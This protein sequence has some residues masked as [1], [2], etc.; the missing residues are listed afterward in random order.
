MII[1]SIM[2]KVINAVKRLESWAEEEQK[3]ETVNA[4]MPKEKPPETQVQS[5]WDYLQI[6]ENT[7][8][9]HL[10]TTVGFEEWVEM[11]E[12]KRRIKELFGME[13]KNERSL[14]PYIKTLADCNLFEFSDIGGK[15]KWRKKALLL[16]FRQ[17][18]AQ[19]AK[20]ETEAEKSA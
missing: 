9:A 1:K 15:R 10:S 7:Q 17:A 20:Q 3:P 5:I 14:Y 2:R 12:I 8:A 16:K 4:T 19:K 6:R 11:P 13:Y 18:A